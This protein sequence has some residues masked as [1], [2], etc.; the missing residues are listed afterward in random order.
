MFMF[1]FLLVITV[2]EKHLY[3]D[4]VKIISLFIIKMS[5]FKILILSCCPETTSNAEYV[6]ALFPLLFDASTEYLVDM[7][8]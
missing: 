1:C 8:S 6:K 7:V 2:I 5:F 4:T 3:R